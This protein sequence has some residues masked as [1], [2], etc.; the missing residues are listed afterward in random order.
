MKL[1]TLVYS[2]RDS[3]LNKSFCDSEV[4]SVT[5]GVDTIF[6]SRP[7]AADDSI[8]G[9]SAKI[10]KPYMLENVEVARYTR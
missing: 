10:L 3:P 5:G 7:E 4:D 8:S 1:P 2:F 6:C 9:A